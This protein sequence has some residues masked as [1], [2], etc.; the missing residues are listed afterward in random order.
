M[1]SDELTLS[2]QG[3][4]H[5]G[6]LFEKVVEDGEECGAVVVPLEAELLVA[7]HLETA[8]T[9]DDDDQFERISE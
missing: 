8:D 4:I 9:A 6:F 2:A 5:Q 3:H 1:G 7:A